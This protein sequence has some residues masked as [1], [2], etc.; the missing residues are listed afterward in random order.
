MNLF[1]KQ[2]KNPYYNENLQVKKHTKHLHDTKLDISLSLC[3]V[4]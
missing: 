2:K 4:S 3:L 1:T